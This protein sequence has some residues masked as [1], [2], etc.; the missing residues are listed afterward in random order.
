MNSYEKMP[1]AN[2]TREKVER[3]L[4]EKCLFLLVIKEIKIKAILRY[5]P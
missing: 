1:W 5:T 2:Y 4:I 3:K